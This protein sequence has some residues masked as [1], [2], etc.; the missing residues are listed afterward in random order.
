MTMGLLSVL[1]ICA[2]VTVDVCTLTHWDTESYQYSK[3]PFFEKVTPT[4][5]LP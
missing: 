4:F 1:A 5:V 3:V 2:L